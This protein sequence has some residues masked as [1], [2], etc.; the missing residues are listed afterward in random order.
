MVWCRHCVKNVPGIRPYDGALAC[1]LCGRILDDFNFS[2]EVTFVKNAAGQSQMAGNIVRSMQSDIS[3]SRERR[4]RKAREDMM[5]LR[6]G[7]GIGDER[8]DVVDMANRF[9]TIAVHRNFT[10]GRKSEQV[11]ASCLYL[12]CRE[13]N[14]PFLLIDFSSY[15]T[16]S[17]YELGAVYLQLCEMLY[18]AEN[19]NYEKLVDPSIFIPRFTNSLLK[20]VHDKAVVKTARDIIASMKR[21]WIQT[22]R[23][24]S[25]ICGAALYIAALSHGIKCS[26]TD[27]V[28]VVHICEATLTKR[29]IE[30]G[31]TES[32]NLT[33]D[34]LTERERE[35]HKRS[36]VRHQSES[37]I[38][39]VLC[40]HQD[41]KPV[42]YGL[43]ESC[44][45]DF[46]T[47]SGGLCGGSNPPAFQ[48]AEQER[49][50][51]AAREE[52]EGGVIS[53]NFDQHCPIGPGCDSVSKSKNQ[54]SGH[55]KADERSDDKAGGTD[56]N[57][58]VSDESG[59]FSDIDDDEVD[60]YIH[61]EEEKHYKKIIW[62]EMN[63]EYLEEQAAK[64]A[65]LK[66]ANEALNASNANCPEAAR[67]LAQATLAAVA[68]SRKEKQQKRAAEAKNAAPPATAVEAV[69]GMLE[70]KRLSSLIDYDALGKLFDETPPAQKSPKKGKT[71]DEGERDDEESVKGRKQERD[72]GRREGNKLEE[73]KEE[74]KEYDFE[75]GEE[76]C[77][78][79]YCEE[80]EGYDYEAF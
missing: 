53:T 35:L 56:G 26:K 18:I 10:K 22:G 17:V 47:V 59:N 50:E 77:F 73:E 39:G 32:G 76:D 61:N 42:G 31:N 52:N 33:V 49:M 44:Y 80:D 64:E 38:D 29:L 45:N 3:S 19:R 46:I 36:F 57:A 51:K 55:G 75:N 13:K 63:R 34:E 16:I 4:I 23:K 70:K 48:R 62:E 66:A 79:G 15:L 25:G 67:K 37:K 68:K 58:E 12:T 69:R 78:Y 21:D 30:F 2:T 65:A 5:N 14:I 74:Y 27:I 43:C 60:G 8:D 6:D 72:G 41:C 11:Q 24:P 1:N 71:E 20:G 54:F 28:K 7:L 40:M 9:Y